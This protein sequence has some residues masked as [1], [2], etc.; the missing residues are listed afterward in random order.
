M[1]L[2]LI[3]IVLWVVLDFN[4]KRKDWSKFYFSKFYFVVS[5]SIVLWFIFFVCNN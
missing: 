4:E 1:N 5:Y 3:N 2:K